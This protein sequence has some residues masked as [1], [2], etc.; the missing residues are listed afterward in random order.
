M[1]NKHKQKVKIKI[2]TKKIN[3]NKL[4]LRRTKEKKCYR[5]KNTKIYIWMEGALFHTTL[6]TYYYTLYDESKKIYLNGWNKKLII[7]I[8]WWNVDIVLTYIPPP[9]AIIFSSVS[10]EI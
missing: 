8:S 6:C 3:E 7:I 4:K 5:I 1:W 10:V 2:L 9:A